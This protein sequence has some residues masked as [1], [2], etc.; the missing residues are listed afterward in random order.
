MSPAPLPWAPPCP[1]DVYVDDGDAVT[2]PDV[3]AANISRATAPTVLG[4]PQQALIELGHWLQAAS[5]QFTTVTPLT[6]QQVLRRDGNDGRTL[7]DVFGWNR[8]FE[9]SL[10]PASVL[11][12]LQQAGALTRCGDYLRSAVRFSSLRDL[13]LVHSAHPTDA[14]NAVFFGPDSY[15]FAGL[16][17]RAL[18]GRRQCVR[19]IAD[20]G[21]GTGVGGLLAARLLASHRPR[22]L[23]TDISPVAL[24]YAAV[25][26]HLA[27]QPE[28]QC[29]VSDLLGGVHEPL[30]LILCNPP[31][32][33]DDAARLYRNGGGA[34]G[35]DLA[36]GAVS[37]SLAAL[38]PGGQLILYTGAPVIDG[39]DMLWHALAPL[40][41]RGDID[42]EYEEI[43]PDVFG[44][45]LRGGAY[46]NVERIAAVGL[47]VRKH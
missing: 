5:Y 32:L 10:L 45:E 23:L 29:L 34:L 44:E 16:I 15:R 38:A 1:V 17:W 35:C 47:V 31:Y 43:D 41:A 33:V 19:T 2:S 4:A 20:I 30:D 27:G 8:P 46:R 40:L 6:H 42:C 14:T 37:E 3:L 7:R 13:L 9:A 21:C 26:A 28:A 22:L 24:R 39:K 11:V 18:R 12:L 25:N 36:V